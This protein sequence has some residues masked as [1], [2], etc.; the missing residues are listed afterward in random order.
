MPENK[1]VHFIPPIPKREKRVGIYCRVSTNS[2]EQLQSLTGTG[3]T[4]N[5]NNSG[6]TSVAISR[7]LYGH[8]HE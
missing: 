1:R 7:C 2:A 5:Q 8:R 3:F 4:P 6:N